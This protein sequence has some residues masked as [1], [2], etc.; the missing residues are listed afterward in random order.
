MNGL[1]QNS[2]RRSIPPLQGSRD[3]KHIFVII[4]LVMLTMG[5]AVLAQAAEPLFV[6]I[7]ERGLREQAQPLGPHALR[8]SFATLAI[9]RLR[10]NALSGER[11]GIELHLFPDVV[12]QAEKSYVELRGDESYSWFGRVQGDPESNVILSVVDGKLAG[13]VMQDGKM[14]RINTLAS[15]NYEITEVDQSSFPPEHGAQEEVL[16]PLGLTSAKLKPLAER[17]ASSQ[18]A[19]EEAAPPN[20]PRKQYIFF[21]SV[22]EKFFK[23]VYSVNIGVVYTGAVAFGGDF[24]NLAAEIQLAVD[25]TN[26]SFLASGIFLQLNLSA[27]AMVSYSETG[28][29]QTDLD[30]LIGKSDGYMDNIH[31]TRDLWN[32]KADIITLLIAD[33]GD[34]CGRG[35]QLDQVETN[36]N[37]YA[38]YAFNVVVADCMVDNLSFAHEVSHN[39]G[40]GHDWYVDT[41]AP[42]SSYNHGFIV[43]DKKKR[44]IMAYWQQCYDL[45]YEC[46][47]VLRYSN[48]TKVLMESGSF[49]GSPLGIPAG[50]YQ[51]ADNRKEINEN[52]YYVA[53]FR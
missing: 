9:G 13:M 22:F 35:S 47:R 33:G 15:G 25:L 11:D 14:F 53:N 3:H 38:E 51:A 48:P 34:D 24:P 49:I 39:L 4:A 19:P 5:S 23:A 44:T 30:R 40:A 10:D 42:S 27:T 1:N 52:R 43:H 16:R 46:P 28:N 8:R 37:Y 12:V 18:P 45:S 41:N 20:S 6:N 50:Q 2:E 31:A 17:G 32:W 26:Q 36:P 7:D 29:T 21:S